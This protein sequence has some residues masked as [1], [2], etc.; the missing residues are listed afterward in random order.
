MSRDVEVQLPSFPPVL[1]P[2]CARRLLAIVRQQLAAAQRN[3]QDEHRLLT[4]DVQTK[5]S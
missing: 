5:V 4:L 3:P 2:R 1:T